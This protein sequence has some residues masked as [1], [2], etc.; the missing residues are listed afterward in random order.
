MAIDGLMN[1]LG[2][3]TDCVGKGYKK[4]PLDI[5]SR[6]DNNTNTNKPALQ[7]QETQAFLCLFLISILCI[8][9]HRLL[10]DMAVCQVGLAIV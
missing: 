4:S 9:R 8:K 7:M 1:D 5:T 6:G 10:A 2:L 3:W